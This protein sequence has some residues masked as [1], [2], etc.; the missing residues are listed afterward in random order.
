MPKASP[1]PGR[2]WTLRMDGSKNRSLLKRGRPAALS[3]WPIVPPPQRFFMRIGCIPSAIDFREFS[4]TAA[5][6][7]LGP[8]LPVSL[9]RRVHFASSSLRERRIGTDKAP[10]V[11]S[12]CRNV[13]WLLSVDHALTPSVRS[14]PSAAIWLF[15]GLSPATAQKHVSN[16]HLDPPLQVYYGRKIRNVRNRTI[17]KVSFSANM[18]PRRARSLP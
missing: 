12:A 6:F 1:M 17:L 14:W 15:A 5:G 11:S 16:I 10:T 4:P 18:G 7:L 13:E 3:P 8:L 9:V 2:C